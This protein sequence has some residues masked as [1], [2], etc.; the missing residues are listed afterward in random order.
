MNI[1]AHPFMK[2]SALIESGIPAAMLDK[3]YRT[4]GQRI[5]WKNGKNSPIIFDTAKLSAYIEEQ[6]KAGDVANA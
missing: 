6:M 4:P 3:I 1:F 2:R 5:C